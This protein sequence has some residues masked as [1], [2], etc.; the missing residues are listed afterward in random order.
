MP[1][2]PRIAVIDGDMQELIKQ[3]ALLSERQLGMNDR[4]TAFM[5]EQRIERADH[6]N[7]LRLLEAHKGD[8]AT[9]LSEIRQR[10]GIFNLIQASFTGL[11]AFIVY[12]LKKI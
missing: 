6:E 9:Q 4:L 8:I 2:R 3:V 7:R 1:T 12:Y 5:S 10:I 11:L